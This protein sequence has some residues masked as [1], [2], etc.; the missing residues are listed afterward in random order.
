MNCTLNEGLF[1]P[2]FDFDAIIPTERDFKIFDDLIRAFKQGK[3][4]FKI[5]VNDVLKNLDRYQIIKYIVLANFYK[6]TGIRSE[7][8]K[9]AVALGY[10]YGEI[11]TLLDKIKQKESSY[12]DFYTQYVVKVAPTA[13]FYRIIAYD[14]K[15]GNPGARRHLCM[16]KKLPSGEYKL[17]IGGA[18]GCNWYD[19]PLFATEAEA[20]NFLS[21]ITKIDTVN[22]LTTF[23]FS[24]TS[25][26]IDLG[27]YNGV[28]NQIKDLTDCVLV[29]TQCGPAY[30]QKNCKYC[31]E[32]LTEEVN[33]LEEAI[34]K[35]DELNPALFN[36][37]ATLKVE[38]KE[39]INEIVEE[40]LKDFIEAEV[41]LTVQDIILTG[42]NASY[43]YTK[44][45][46]LDIHIIADTSKIEDTLNLHKVIYNAYKSAFNKKF[47]IELNKVPVE[48]YVETQ[49]T[50]LVSNGIYSV[51]NDEWVKEPTK[52]D[53]P[54]VDQ[55]AID[56]AF[57]PWEKRYKALVDKITDE[58]EDE[59]EID[60]FIDKLYELRQKGL[61][62]EGEYS[63]GNL[64]FKEVRNNG[65]LDNLKE[66]RHKVIA[67]RLS[68]HEDFRRLTETERRD[69]YNK[70]SRL[71]NYQPIIQLNGLFELYNVKEVDLPI[72][73]SNLRRQTEV[74]YVQ[75]SAEKFD[76]SRLN[77]SGIP[78]KLYKIIGKLR[79]N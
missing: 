72:V 65:Y 71:T 79:L 51:M 7:A 1:T 58:T 35:H 39:K 28:T 44:D 68:L 31:V 66:L 46:D 37:D 78:A 60:K 70:I 38:V 75:Q 36:E 47:E 22:D 5:I 43:N 48:I 41:E 32:S 20:K 40:F 12:I 49:D 64:V 14:P 23:K 56:K 4:S 61:A 29:N 27:T 30:I 19:E 69:Y 42:S 77:Y 21:N 34:E 16:R 45:S 62:E 25:K 52:D 73:L 74:E 67:Q 3:V 10:D 55:E 59:S 54:E 53:I 63:I 18:T 57:K 11:S 13:G 24:I 2:I 26:P 6:E 9:Q 15:Y 33:E 76:F 50:P 17:S 8:I